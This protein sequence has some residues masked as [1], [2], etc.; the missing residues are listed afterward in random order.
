MGS[1]TYFHIFTTVNVP[2]HTQIYDATTV[3]LPDNTIIHCSTTVVV[4]RITYFHVLT[5]VVVPKSIKIMCSPTVF[6]PDDTYFQSSPTVFVPEHT[7]LHMFVTVFVPE[8]TLISLFHTVIASKL[9]WSVGSYKQLM[10]SCIE[11]PSTSSQL[12]TQTFTTQMLTH[13]DTQKYAGS[14]RNA[15]WFLS[16]QLI[17]LQH[18][19]TH[20]DE[21]WDWNHV[22]LFR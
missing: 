17:S 22:I 11:I 10:C 21:G 13:E 20:T 2:K 18:T 15:V 19:W 1:S 3:F 12:H 14:Q 5:T 6:V 9:K 16:W 8:H 4:P 7:S